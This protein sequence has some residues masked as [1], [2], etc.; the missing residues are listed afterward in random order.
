MIETARNLLASGDLLAWA[1]LIGF[2]FTFCT[3]AFL[4]V[5][6]LCKSAAQG[7]RAM[8]AAMDVEFPESSPC[9]VP[10]CTLHPA[11]QLGQMDDARPQLR[12]VD[13]T[14]E[15]RTRNNIRRQMR[16]NLETHLSALN[17]R[18]LK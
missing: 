5:T 17:P 14:G 4:F 12:M 13:S 6:A 9:I 18:I 2:V 10:G 7:D 16:A 8:V 3:A 15:A 11:P 1:F